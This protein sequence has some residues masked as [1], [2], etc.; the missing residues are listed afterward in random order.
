MSDLSISEKKKELSKMGVIKKQSSNALIL[1]YLGVVLG[2]LSAFFIF[3]KFLTKDQIG[4]LKTLEAIA[5][6]IVPFIYLGIPFGI[7]K[8]LK[9]HQIDQTLNHVM[10]KMFAVLICTTIVASIVFYI[11][12][13]YIVEQFYGNSSILKQYILFEIPVFVGLS[14]LIVLSYVSSSNHI[15]VFPRFL[16]R[17]LSRLIQI[18]AVLLLYFS[19]YSES[20]MVLMI[21]LSYVIP[22]LTLFFYCYKKGFLS[23]NPKQVFTKNEIS[24]SEE[25]KY[26][27]WTSIYMIGVAVTSNIGMIMT[28]SLLGLDA[29]AIFF[30]GYYL[31]YVLEIPAINFSF[32]MKPI[33]SVSFM[34]DDLPNIEK[35]Y[36]KSS[37]IQTL[38]SGLLFIVIL[39]NLNSFFQIMPNGLEFVD[40]WWVATIIGGA[41]VIRNLSGCQLDI[42][43]MS[44]NYRFAVIIVGLSAIISFLLYYVLIQRFELIGAAIAT[45]ISFLLQSLVI[46]IAVYKFYK[47]TPFQFSTII[48]LLVILLCLSIGLLLP[49]LLNPYFSI[50]Y[51]SVFISFIYIFFGYYMKLSLDIND[52]I[53]SKLFAK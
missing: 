42:L 31:G 40:A 19:F 32:I 36:K 16:E 46:G 25:I 11:F 27:R 14:W 52:F 7:S 41:I 15:I 24:Y 1:T 38:V 45:A 47:I 22:M 49:D 50:L 51:K 2:V 44:S 37:V 4:L 18:I 5:L 53:N 23:F 33:L 29:V 34:N 10:T 3:P 39:T 48:T 26:I 17:I 28:G 8:F 20:G 12:R 43:L 6:L 35:L 9:K 30:I 13:Y 21:T